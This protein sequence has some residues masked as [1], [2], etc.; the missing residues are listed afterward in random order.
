MFTSSF[1]FGNGEQFIETEIKYLSRHFNNI[2][3]YPLVV[4]GDKRDVPGNVIVKSH[5]LYSPY[6]RIS[7]LIRYFFQI[8]HVYL[9]ELLF[10]KHR[11][12]YLT[13]GRH[14]FNY[15]LHRF[16]DAE[17]LKKEL[18][19]YDLNNTVLYFYW[20]DLWATVMSI[21]KLKKRKSYKTVARMH[22]GDYDEAQNPNGYFPFR[23]FEMSV[24]NDLVPVSNYGVNYLINQFPS[25][26]KS[27]SLS[28][29]G[30]KDNSI[31]PSNTDE[32]FIIVSCSFLIPLKRVHLIVEILKHIQ[33]NVRWIHFG[34]GPL[35]NEIKQLSTYLPN[36]IKTDFKG[37]VSNSE[38]I[39]FYAKQH[40]DLFIN[41]S[42]L[43][44]IPVSV[45][46]AI[47]FGIPSAGCKICGVPEI[48]NQETGILLDLNFEPK[49]AA[50]KIQTLLRSPE[51]DKLRISA[52]KFWKENY[53][54]EKNYNDFI[55]KH[56]LNSCAA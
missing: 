34:D 14:H 29:L 31:N 35:L 4:S 47:S 21:V 45:M 6:Q 30:V 1:P 32:E 5:Q 50:S 38:I 26:K 52:R 54:A 19:N 42:E 11:L 16:N 49:D 2:Y 55:D 46:E 8:I 40:V 18:E 33:Y 43:E 28:R 3:I 13:K 22:G 7:L 20:F 37:Y 27:F 15:L 44:G 17:W 53:D 12:K 25:R 23:Y 36:N 9:Y 56:L 48:V 10:S 39:R 41:V 24:W 51:A